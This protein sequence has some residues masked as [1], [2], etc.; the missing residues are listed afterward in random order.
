MS[1]SGRKEYGEQM[2][3]WIL[4]NRK[5]DLKRLSEEF[6]IDPLVAKLIRNREVIADEEIEAYLQPSLD[7]LHDPFLLADMEKAVEL[8]QE[9]IAEKWK[10]LAVTDF[11]CDGICTG[12]I[13]KHGLAEVGGNVQIEIPERIRD[14][15][16]INSR[17]VRQAAA[18]GVRLIITG[19]NGIAAAQVIAEAKAYGIQVVV[20]DHH[21]VPYMLEQG[22]KMYQLPPADAVV[23]PKRA[24]CSYPYEGI[25][26]AVV[27]WKLIQ[28]LYIA[29]GRG[30]K[31][32]EAF[33]PYAAIATVA[34]VMDLRDEN[35]AIVKK[36]LEAINSL[37]GG[38][39]AAH[40]GLRQL[41]EANGIE[42]VTS[43]SIGFVLGP[44]LNA[45][46]RLETADMA[47]RL[48]EA[49]EQAEARQL[50]I[51]LKELN[52][53]RKGMTEDGI[54][55]ALEIIQQQKMEEDKVL[56]LK[57]EAVHESIVG[58]IAGRIK[59]RYTRPVLVLTQAEDGL[60]GSG[61]S[62]ESYNIFEKVSQCK[63]LLEH[64]GGHPMA[65][66]LS[67]KEENLSEL[68]QRLN[69][70]CGLTKEDLVAQVR[71]D[72][73]VDLAY[74]TEEIIRGLEIME[75][76]GK[77][78]GKPLFGEKEVSI[79]RLAYIGKENNYLRLNL[80]G[81]DSRDK[82]ALYFGDGQGLVAYLQ[83]KY[84]EEEVQKAFQG[85][86]NQIQLM[87]AYYPQIN[88]YNGSSSI[89]FIISHYR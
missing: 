45:S 28:A 17:I 23:D 6:G 30:I 14:G 71:L 44:C 75:P 37:I 51:H 29:M 3:K 18:Q 54:R 24:D 10:I 20:T 61:R 1:L 26:G 38:E 86:P 72:A 4:M 64:F 67:M 27:A 16:G 63:D 33:L 41:I 11:D 35:R 8:V 65:C 15:Y 79:R 25:C 55:Q 32:A 9:A 50:A 82:K 31:K 53:E 57:L 58:I 81:K 78:N 84:G 34:D 36:G 76:F 42:N 70:E 62:V 69:Q 74:F 49:Q 21:E 5:A 68:R 40:L 80:S 83:E 19:D 87:I 89:Q 73:Q 13:L 22:E 12:Y 7:Q 60:K 85:E 52:K 39:G 47:I 59:E 88:V 56:V 66:G 48:L 77:G 2:E 46:G 43:Y